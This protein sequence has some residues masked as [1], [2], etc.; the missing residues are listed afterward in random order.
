MKKITLP[1]A[2]VLTSP[3]PV[4][5]VCTEKADG[6]ANLAHGLVVGRTFPTILDDRLCNGEALLQR[7]NGAQKPPSRAD[8][9]GRRAQRRR[10][11]LR[12]V[13]GPRHRQGGKDGRRSRIASR[14]PIRVPAR[15]RVAIV[16]DLAEFHEVGDHYLYVCNV[17]AVYANEEETPLFAWDGYAKIAPVPVS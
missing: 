5:L 16:C 10:A 2:S 12:L 1:K 8:H 9:S 15:S 11:Y 4:T 6:S 17:K 7:R 3:N 13:H 14:Y